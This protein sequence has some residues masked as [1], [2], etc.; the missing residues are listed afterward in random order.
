[1][2]YGYPHLWKPPTYYDATTL[3]GDIQ[4]I[5]LDP[6]GLLARLG[7]ESREYS[8]VF[9]GKVGLLHILF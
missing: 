6:Q 4:K 3:S 8:A 5:H 1:M 9:F 7:F 2:I